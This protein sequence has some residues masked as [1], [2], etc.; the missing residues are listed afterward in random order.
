MP[1]TPLVRS[2]RSRDPETRIILRYQSRVTEHTWLRSAADTG[3]ADGL[4]NKMTDRIPQVWDDRLYITSNVMDETPPTVSSIE[5]YNPTVQNTNRQTLTYKVTFSEAVTGVD[6]F[7]FVFSPDSVG[8]G[9]NGNSPVTAISGSGDTYHVAVQATRD[10]TYNIDLVSSGHGIADIAD[11]SMVDV[12]PVSGVDETYVKTGSGDMKN[13]T[14]SSIER[15][16][17]LNEYT[18]N[19]SLTYKIMFNED[20]TGVDRTD[21]VLSPDSTGKFH[22]EWPND[23]IQTSSPNTTI[24]TYTIGSDVMTVLDSGVTSSVRLTLDALTT[25]YPSNVIDVS[26]IAPDGTIMEG[27][28]V[29]WWYGEETYSFDVGRMGI[30]GFLIRDSTAELLSNLWLNFLPG[31]AVLNPFCKDS[32]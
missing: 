30:A 16:D 8:G 5:R 9:N 13:P 26:L 1:T 11:N 15:H 25:G 23:F 18:N 3:I 22:I 31:R 24:Q 6:A 12:I 2:R 17:P 19:E 10:G 29:S 20:V 14:L 27:D 21:F 4:G 28:D 7:D 32:Q